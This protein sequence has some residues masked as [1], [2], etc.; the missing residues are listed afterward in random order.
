MATISDSFAIFLEKHIHNNDL[1]S[2]QSGLD[3]SIACRHQFL[4]MMNRAFLTLV[5][6]VLIAWPYRQT[7]VKSSVIRH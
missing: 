3:M 2:I 6:L 4:E 5:A 1:S 7:Q